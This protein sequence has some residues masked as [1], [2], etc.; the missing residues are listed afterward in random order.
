MG[1]SD[2]DDWL[3][4]RLVKPPYRDDIGKKGWLERFTRARP[5]QVRA[6][7]WTI[8]Q[9][10]RWTR[11]L[12]IAFLSDFH[13]GAHAGD[14]A[15]LE[16]IVAEAA[17]HAPDLVLYGGDFVNMIPFGGGRVPPKVIARIL[18][19][20]PAPLGRLAVIGNHDRNYGEAEVIGA[21]RE[22]GITVLASEPHL[23]AFE[24]A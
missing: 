15:R 24:H 2:W 9:W 12:R 10:P 13:T 8:S 23:L 5:H 7:R 18:A 19:R 1:F 17:A 21:L 14:V 11:P 6:L 16:T 20:L 3:T 4:R 22:H